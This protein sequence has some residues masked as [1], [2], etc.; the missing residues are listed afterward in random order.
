MALID[1]TRQKIA[2]KQEQINQF[3]VAIAE[4]EGKD[5]TSP[6]P[7]NVDAANRLAAVMKNAKSVE[8]K[9]KNLASAKVA[10]AQVK[11]EMQELQLSLDRQVQAEKKLKASEE[12]AGA[13]A[14]FN[15]AADQ[16]IAAFAEVRRLKTVNPYLAPKVPNLTLPQTISMK[17]AMFRFQPAPSAAGTWNITEVRN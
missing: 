5:P 17:G 3:S 6:I 10:Q 11:S 9:Q 1:E 12:F 4:L 14:A 7:E 2:A 15:S 8:E 16:M 13:V